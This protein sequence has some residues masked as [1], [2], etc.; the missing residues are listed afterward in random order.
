M[1]INVILP[2]C[3]WRS[4]SVRQWKVVSN[5]AEGEDDGSS[6]SLKP[7][8]VF[9][10]DPCDNCKINFMGSIY[11]AMVFTLFIFP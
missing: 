6:E 9:S 8:T 3:R 1:Y 4:G 2:F 10:L 5:E 7:I 11:V